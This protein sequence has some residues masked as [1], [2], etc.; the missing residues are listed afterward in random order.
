MYEAGKEL[1]KELGNGIKEG[2]KNAFGIGVQE[3]AQKMMDQ[4]K[5]AIKKN[6]LE[7]DTY[8]RQAHAAGLSFDDNALRN[9]L[10]T[11]ATPVSNTT[12]KSVNQFAPVIN[13]SGPGG[14][15]AGQQIGNDVVKL[16]KDY[17]DNK[18]RVSF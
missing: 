17:N 8:V 11:P 5:A 2:F 3:K 7:F 18:K 15:A 14:P 1:L 4:I 16:M 6:P 13:Y 10:L 9:E 12:T